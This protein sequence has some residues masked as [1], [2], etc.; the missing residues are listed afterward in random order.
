MCVYFALGHMTAFRFED[1][2]N[3]VLERNDMLASF[4]IHLFDQGRERCRFSTTHRARHQNQSILVA[5]QQF[6]MLGQSELVHRPHLRV[7]DAKDEIDAQSLTDDA[8]AITAGRIRVGK[9][10]VTAVIQLRL[11][12]VR[13]KAFGQGKRL[14]GCETLSVRPDRLERSMQSPDRG[15]I[16]SEMHIRCAGSLAERKI[17]IDVRERVRGLGCRS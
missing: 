16:Y 9:I 5:R 2:L 17:F 10:G 1:V 8:R 12:R 4:A 15:G 6:Q 11:L 13:E 3:R 7:D 14:F